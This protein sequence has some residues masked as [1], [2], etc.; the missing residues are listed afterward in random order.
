MGRELV[1]GVPRNLAER[2]SAEYVAVSMDEAGRIIY[3]PVCEVW[4][5]V[6]NDSVPGGI[7]V[8]GF[9]KGSEGGSQA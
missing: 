9:L 7:R 8:R 3:T 5:K 1:I 4:R 6:R 2:L